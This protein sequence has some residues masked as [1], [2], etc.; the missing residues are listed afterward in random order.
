MIKSVLLLSMV[1]RWL[2]FILI[3]RRLNQGINGCRP[4]IESYRGITELPGLYTILNESIDKENIFFYSTGSMQTTKRSW[5]G[6]QIVPV[7]ERDSY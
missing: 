2:I 6:K 7:V 4:A 3:T 1:T 5:I